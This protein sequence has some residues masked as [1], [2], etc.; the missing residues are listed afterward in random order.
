[1][2]NYE[3]LVLAD[4]GL[5]TYVN[6]KI[7]LFCRCGTP[8]YVAPEVINIK[9]MKSHYSSVCDVY[10]VG[11]IFYFLLS[12]KPAFNAKSYNSIVKQ[13]RIASIDFKA[14]HLEIVPA[15]GIGKGAIE[16]ILS[17]GL[18]EKNAGE[19]SRKTDNSKRRS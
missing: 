16:D 3:S 8:G 19:R 18:A 7:Y 14:K 4:F 10:S 9:D 6:E 1:M 12:G 17:S 15:K 11:L 5:A 13:N 2:N